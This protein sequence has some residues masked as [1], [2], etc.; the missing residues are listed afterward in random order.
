[1]QRILFPTDFSVNS[2]NAIYYG[3]ALYEDREKYILL[4]TFDIPY[5]SSEVVDSMK[6]FMEEKVESQMMKLVQKIHEDF[7][8]LELD[9]ETEFET[10]NLVDTVTK[11]V[12]E[13]QIKMVVM[14]TQGASGIAERIIGTQASS[15]IKKVDCPVLSIPTKSKPMKMERIVLAV[16]NELPIDEVNFLPL[17]DLARKFSSTIMVV[18]VAKDESGTIRQK[19]KISTVLGNIDHSFHNI[20]HKNVIVGLDEF[21]DQNNASILA[22]VTYKT[23][24]F[25]S[26]FQGSTTKKMALHSSIPLLALHHLN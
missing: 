14:G 23:N 10:G 3:L 5:S 6:D 16:D 8:D 22:M 13:E 25:E 18:H 11:Y 20:E 4:H 21:V 17:L 7:P 9:I 12:K 1:M 2:I 15:V 26:I 19:D 24:F